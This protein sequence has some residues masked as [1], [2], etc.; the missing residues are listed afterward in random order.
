MNTKTARA[1]LFI[2]IAASVLAATSIYISTRKE[3]PPQRLGVTYDFSG[4]SVDVGRY[5][6]LAL[7]PWNLGDV[8]GAKTLAQVVAAGTDTTR[9][10]AAWLYLNRYRKITYSQWRA[11]TYAT[12]C[13][14]DGAWRGEAANNIARGFLNTY[15][16]VVVPSGRY[17]LNAECVVPRGGITGSSSFWSPG[18]GQGHG[19]YSTEL[20]M[21]DDI[22]WPSGPGSERRMLTTPNS[23]GS[24][25]NFSY[26]ESMTIQK[27]YLHGPDKKGDG[28]TRIGLF[29]SWMGECTYV[30][31]VRADYW[32]HGFVARGGVPLTIGTM[33]AFWNST[34]GLSLLGCAQAT[35]SIQTLSGDGCGRLLNLAAGYGS[36]AGGI[37][38][39][40]LLKNED[41]T[42][43]GAPVSNQVAV[44]A[45]GQYIVNIGI[46]TLACQNGAAPEAMFVL[47]PTLPQYGTQASMLRVGGVYHFGFSNIVKNR[48][49]G[50]TWTA[51]QYSGFGFAHYAKWDKVETACDD[52][53]KVGGGTGGGTTPPPSTGQAYP[54]TGWKASAYKFNSDVE[55]AEFAIDLTPGRHWTNGENMRGDRTQRFTV[56][57][58]QPRKIGRVVISTRSDRT[59]DYPRGLYAEV[60]SNGT[61][62]TAAPVT[63]TGTSTMTVD[64]TTDPTAVHFRLA[65]NVALG[66][67]WSI[68]ELQVYP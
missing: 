65:P 56:T 51:P 1:L 57:M 15:N 32:T 40:G 14:T 37:V 17:E 60:S 48:V 58:D 35:F 52:L 7:A 67:W 55:K 19:F 53:V 6:N 23:D 38:N 18:N 2:G 36:P 25:G 61:T 45:E 28:I 68:D 8:D 47:N 59:S 42:T 41:G 54:R 44:Y 39:V 30:N 34:G 31:Q 63:I 21:R 49:T 4:E 33:S 11:L 66:H 12:V 27:L 29:M 13:L 64:F 10:Q 50:S 24:A 5:H 16:F 3:P 26:N 9:F 46:A 22:W 62:W 20:F 43:P